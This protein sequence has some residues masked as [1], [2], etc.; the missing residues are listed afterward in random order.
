M[1]GW[2]THV[3]LGAV[4]MLCMAVGWPVLLKTVAHAGLKRFGLAIWAMFFCDV[5]VGGLFFEPRIIR[6]S[7]LAWGLQEYLCTMAW[8][9]VRSSVPSAV[10]ILWLVLRNAVANEGWVRVASILAAVLLANYLLA[11]FVYSNFGIRVYE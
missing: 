11:S 9:F 5:V 4:M 7:M 2:Q 6:H 10:L 8:N 1:G 3:V